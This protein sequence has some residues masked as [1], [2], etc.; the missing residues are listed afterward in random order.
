MKKLRKRIIIFIIIVLICGWFG[1]II[2]LVLTKQPEGQS[3]GSL[4]WLLTPFISSLL[5]ALIHK[6]D[7]KT[8]GLKLKLK[9]NGKW[10]LVSLTAFP[11]IAALLIGIGSITKSIDLTKFEVRGFV[12]VLFSWFLYSFFRTILEEMAWRGFLQERLIRFE[13]NDW[14]IY[15]ITALVWALWH[16]PY[17]LFFYKGNGAEMIVSCFFILFSWSILYSEIYRM[18]RSIWPCVLLHTTSN[19]IQYTMLENYITIDEKRELIFSPTGSITACAI[20][21]LL[22]L[23]IRNY[24]LNK[25]KI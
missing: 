10:Y 6:S 23:I 17:Y 3:L 4:V 12:T 22:G 18:T 1:K 20:T 14:L 21:I 15:L 2:D 5:L 24:R 19:A 8:L 9:G 11:L 16:I 25:R 13:V 7:Y